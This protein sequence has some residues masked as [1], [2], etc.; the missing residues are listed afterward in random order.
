MVQSSQV[1][2]IFVILPVELGLQSE[3]A[4]VSQEWHGITTKTDLEQID[5]LGLFQD[6]R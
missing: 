1:A 4:K 6:L 5:M 2:R 3:N